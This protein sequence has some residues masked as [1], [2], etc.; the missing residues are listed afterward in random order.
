MNWGNCPVS[1]VTPVFFDIETTGLR[2]DRGAKITEMALVD[3]E[4]PQFQ[5]KRPTLNEDHQTLSTQLSLLFK[6]FENRIVIG[7]NLQ[8]D[9]RFIAYEADRFGLE[10]PS[11]QFIDTLEL[12][13]RTLSNA[14]DFRLEALV[15]RLD[16]QVEDPFH[17]AVTDAQA[18]HA[19]FWRLV[20]TGN[21]QTVAAAGL[22]H[23]NWTNF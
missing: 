1:V 18:T 2:P 5:W 9:L 10:G 17:T 15:R 12:A 7:H 14:T 19:L 20:E 23:L 6:H 16:L 8:F 22:K 4:G 11:L 13:R 21:V 3:H